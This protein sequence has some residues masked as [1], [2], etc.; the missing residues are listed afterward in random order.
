METNNLRSIT[1][2]R[3]DPNEPKR[4]KTA[5][6][7]Y[8]LEQRPILL[9]EN[10]ELKISEVSRLIAQGWKNLSQSEKGPYR[11]LADQDKIRYQQEMEEYQKTKEM[12]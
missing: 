2:R 9:R 11:S 3:K 8:A 7:F 4:N 12:K 6:L 10:Q 5:Y 1:R